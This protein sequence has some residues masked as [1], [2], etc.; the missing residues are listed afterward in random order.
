MPFF[1]YKTLTTNSLFNLGAVCS[2]LFKISFI[3]GSKT[4]FFSASHC[5][6]PLAGWYTGFQ[7]CLIA[8]FVK[9]CQTIATTTTYTTPLMVS[10]YHIPTLC[11]S[12]YFATIVQSSDVPRW[13]RLLMAAIPLCCFFLFIFHP[14]G[15]QAR[16]Y[17]W[18]WCIPL[19][20]ALIPHTI[21]FI[22]ALASTCIAH[23]VGSIIWIYLIGPA[24]SAAWLALIPVAAVERLFFASG[25][26][27]IAYATN[28]F[29]GYNWQTTWL[30]PKLGL[31]RNKQILD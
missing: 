19:L 4:A 5:I 23:A 18:L 14:V 27:L 3:V 16:S 20:S 15:A 8:F 1:S 11:A 22:H 6:A 12:L 9:I 17:T 7:G 26:T 13:R 21:F 29:A 10:A 25:M 30:T 28:K 31:N 2:R 24:D